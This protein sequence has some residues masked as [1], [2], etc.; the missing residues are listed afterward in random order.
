MANRHRKRRST[1]LIIR[2]MHMK[3]TMRYHFMLLRMS[4]I[5]IQEI[6]SAGEDMEKRERVFT[7]EPLFTSIN[8]CSHYGKTVWKLLKKLTIEPPCDPAIPL[9]G[10]YLKNIKTLI[11][12]DMHP[13]VY[14]SIIYNWQDMEIT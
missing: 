1:S 13:Y 4:I 9:L 12:K 7:G 14:C 10:I 3:T 8:W 5:K 6:T 11:Q 2:E